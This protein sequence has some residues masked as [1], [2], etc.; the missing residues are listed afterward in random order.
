MAGS[1]KLAFTPSGKGLFAFDTGVLKGRLKLDGRFMGLYPVLDAAT[2]KE[3]TRPPGIFS[4]YRVFET[5]KRYGNAARDWPTA[6]RLLPDGAVE[7]K[8][9]SAAKHPIE[10]TAVFRWTAP[11]TLDLALAVT[12][13][14]DMPCFELFMSSYF[15]Q[16]FRAAMYMKRE[17]EEK[18][19]FV[20]VDRTPGSR[21]GYV[22]FPKDEAAVR[23]IQ[24]GR[25]KIPPS[26]V[27]WGIE[28]WL[29]A[30]LAIRRDKA[31]GITGVM[32]CRP[33]DCFAFSSPWNPAS[34]KGGGY[35]SLYQ[36]LFGRDLKA[37]ETAHA[38]MRLIIARN[39]SD[40]QAVQRYEAFLKEENR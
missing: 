19:R 16:G 24:D 20:P 6:T 33:G 17:G 2:G 39:L 23:M 14:K 15:T 34:P 40:E 36:C 1:P 30:P 10:M 13:Q 8:W 25:W 32:M 28:R 21:G 26:A 18:A 22:M 3:L 27:D 5:H 29:A 31:A 4:P 12:P 35:R 37:G 9:P 38:R 7:A 11:D